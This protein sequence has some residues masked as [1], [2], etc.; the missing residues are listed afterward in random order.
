MTAAVSEVFGHLVVRVSKIDDTAFSVPPIDE[1]VNYSVL[2]AVTNQ[3]IKDDNF[4]VVN[5]KVFKR[6]EC[7]PWGFENFV[8]SNRVNICG[9]VLQKSSIFVLVEV[10]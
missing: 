4:L 5:R 6:N 2:V 1:I 9:K 7:V 10:F 8:T 3:I